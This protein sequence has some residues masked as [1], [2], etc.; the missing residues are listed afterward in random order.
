MRLTGSSREQPLDVG[1]A[2][3]GMRDEH[4]RVVLLHEDARITLVPR[5]RQ[6]D[7]EFAPV[8]TRHDLVR[9]RDR[10]EQQQPLAVVNCI[11][12]DDLRPYAAV[13]L[14]MR[15]LPMPHIRRDL[16]HGRDRTAHRAAWLTKPHFARLY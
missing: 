16:L 4:G 10:V 6:H 14:R 7:N 3:L 12:R 9:R 2:G 15:S 5:V 1:I 11:R 8:R 13:P